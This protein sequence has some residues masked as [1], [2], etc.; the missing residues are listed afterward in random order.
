MTAIL[1]IHACQ[2]YYDIILIKIWILKIFCIFIAIYLYIAITKYL[3]S[4]KLARKSIYLTLSCLLH[5]KVY[6]V[7]TCLRFVEIV[8]YIWHCF[9]KPSVNF[10]TALLLFWPC[11]LHILICIKDLVV[12]RKHLNLAFNYKNNDIWPPFFGLLDYDEDKST[13]LKWFWNNICKKGL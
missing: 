9:Y 8:S 4:L 1:Y 10:H 5:N 7:V 12:G 3:L 11:D 13:T 2:I 6:M